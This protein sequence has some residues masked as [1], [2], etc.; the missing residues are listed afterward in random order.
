MRL[1]NR[2]EFPLREFISRTLGP[3][4][5]YRNPWCDR[6][7]RWPPPTPEEDDLDREQYGPAPI[8]A[9]AVAGPLFAYEVPGAC[10]GHTAGLARVD[11]G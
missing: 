11:F 3:G 7:M 5:G 10:I 6:G 9:P 4:R 8:A 1:C 2:T